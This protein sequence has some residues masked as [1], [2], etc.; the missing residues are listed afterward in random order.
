MKKCLGNGS[1]GH[2]NDSPTYAIHN[3]TTKSTSKMSEVSYCEKNNSPSPLV[4]DDV[5]KG[6]NNSDD[7]E[8]EYGGM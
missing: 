1:V 7:L 6:S 8:N 3:S 5:N 4:V 2:N